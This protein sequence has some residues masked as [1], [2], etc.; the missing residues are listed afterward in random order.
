MSQII[1]LG[2]RV[3]LQTRST[4]QE[5]GLFEA[6]VVEPGMSGLDVGQIVIVRRLFGDR[7]LDGDRELFIVHADDIYAKVVK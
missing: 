7:W 6:V 3:V 5:S 1:P 4:G 2:N